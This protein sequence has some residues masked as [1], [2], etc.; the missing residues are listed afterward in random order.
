MTTLYCCITKERPDKT[1]RVMHAMSRGWRE[2][3]SVVMT[4]PPPKDENPFAIW[5]Q[6][7]LAEKVVPVAL[8]EKRPFY[9]FDNGF[10]DSAK[11][12]RQGHYRISYRGIS[13]ILINK[14][15]PARAMRHNVPFQPW[16]KSGSKIIV[17]MP[18]T[19]S[20]K[21]IGLNLTQ[22]CDEIVDRVE[23]YTDRPIHVR[24]KG[25]MRP[26]EHELR[27]AWALVTHSSNAGTVAAIRGVPVFCGELCPAAPVGNHDLA[28]IETP[29]MPDRAQW[30]ESLMCQQ[31][32]LDEISAGVAAPHLEM[33]RKQV[34]K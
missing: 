19:G 28:N 33:V 31:F 2:G 11:G 22:W 1:A 12:G 20:G 4:G 6:L 34:D 29:A 21:C 27:D 26:L 9:H 24:D 23:Q 5:G 16:R 7:W 13:P 18:G 15:D 14:P 25:D 10:W 17:A 32:T 8:A 30:W 3:A